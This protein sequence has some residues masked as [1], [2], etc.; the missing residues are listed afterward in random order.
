MSIDNDVIIREYKESKNLHQEFCIKIEG[1]IKDIL[2]QHNV[3]C[4]S[5]ESRVKQESSLVTK[6]I[7]SDGKY[8]ALS[9]I[10]DITGIRII[11]YFAEDVDKIAS[12]IQGEFEVDK[13][14]SVDKRS[15]LDPDR[16]GYLSLHYVVKLNDHRVTLAEYSRFKDIKV[17][18]QIRSILQH[19]W[20]EI[21]HDLG[22]KSKT[23]I[24]N[25]VRRDFSRLAGLLELADEEFL[26][27]RKTLEDYNESIREELKT[28]PA[29][30][31]IDKDSVT[32]LLANDL[33]EDIDANICKIG[34]GDQMKI[35]GIT[36][37]NH[38][39]RLNYLGFNT[40]D[41]VLV[42]LDKHKDSIIN[43][44]DLWLDK[45][46]NEK[47]SFSKG[48]SLFYL[49]YLL[50]GKSSNKLISQYLAEFNIGSFDNKEINA[51]EIKKTYE[52]VATQ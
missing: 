39:K 36:V 2:K 31:M 23:S 41:E 47:R 12:I 7:K 8:T 10:T 25:V 21:E 24:P 11:T 5:I 22:Y 26:R 19:A 44:A 45:E 49:A 52:Q 50:V 28:T 20:A 33:V 46:N 27:I 15:K 32:Q 9:D 48:V 16:F 30:V 42:S 14:N 18:I 34:N 6:V 29:N 43:F 3:N 40:I 13:E 4:H 35:D 1:L 51:A 38:V 37:E 17:E